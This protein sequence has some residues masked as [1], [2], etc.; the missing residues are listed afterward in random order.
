MIIRCYCDTIENIFNI[1][2]Q[3]IFPVI[4]KLLFSYFTSSVETNTFIFYNYLSS[5]LIGT[6]NARTFSKKS[7]TAHVLNG[8]YEKVP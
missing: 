3:D 8:V 7:S 6:C 2:E 5:V 1:D 4:E